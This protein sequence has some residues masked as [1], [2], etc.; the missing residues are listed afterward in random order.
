MTINADAS[1]TL[2]SFC[3]WQNDINPKIDHPQHHDIGILLTRDDIC[4]EGEAD[5]CDLL[6]LANMA[7]ACT[8]TESC[9]INEDK[10]IILGVVVAHE[11]GHMYVCCWE[12]L[13]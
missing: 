13:N 6:G 5:S 3:K 10:G 12:F 1:A 2:N 8:P 7:S 11:I 9:A 4:S